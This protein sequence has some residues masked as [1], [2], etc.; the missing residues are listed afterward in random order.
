MDFGLLLET[1]MS[2]VGLLTAGGVMSSARTIE[3]V[4]KLRSAT[5]AGRNIEESIMGGT[6]PVFGSQVK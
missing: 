5:A 4:A 3:T 2:L 1:V 6:F